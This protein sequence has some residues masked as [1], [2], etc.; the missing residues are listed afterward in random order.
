MGLTPVVY[1]ALAAACAA[2]AVLAAFVGLRPARETESPLERIGAS[3]EDESPVTP[4][5]VEPALWRL[6]RQ[7][8][9]FGY[10][11]APKGGLETIRKELAGAG[12][13]GRMRP[14]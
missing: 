12:Y 14:T 9:A 5:E 1:A 2:L 6:A 7:S 3:I 13:S 11:L 8:M 10:R 4:R